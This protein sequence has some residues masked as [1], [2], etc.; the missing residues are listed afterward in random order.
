MTD[1]IIACGFDTTSSNTGVNKGSCTLLQ[2]LLLRQLL[3]LACRHH[4][5]ELVIAVVFI[6]LL[7]KTTGP[8]VTL[9]K[10]L[11]S[12]W[13]SLDLN[14]LQLP[15]IPASYRREVEDLLL[16]IDERLHPDNL[17]NLTRCDYREFL[18]LAKLFLGGTILRKSIQYLISNACNTSIL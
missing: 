6:V 2:Q 14:V 1:S 3:W 16:F 9:F 7:G 10:I 5:L 15:D 11:K 13:D 8:E 18:E 4:I 17:E 12:S